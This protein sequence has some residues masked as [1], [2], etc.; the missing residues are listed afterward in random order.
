M[1]EEQTT[2]ADVPKRSRRGWLWWVG[3]AIAALAIYNLSV[4]VPASSD[5][6]EDGRAS[7][8]SMVVYRTW[9][10]HPTDITVDLRDVSTA[11][12]IDLFRG[13][14]LA[15]E[16]L[17]DREFGQVTLARGGKPVF[18]MSG[19]D[20]AAYGRYGTSLAAVQ[21]LPEQM[22]LPSGEQAFGE[23]TGGWLGVMG[24]QLEDV[25]VMAEEWASGQ[26]SSYRS[27]Y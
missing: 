1:T 24:R 26:T 2:R 8:Y 27:T 22:H 23:W 4:T 5:L 3:G 11:A 25:N 10:V 18:V 16:G 6:S 12:R 15:A 21:S 20:F 9:L 7:G 19:D 17:G 14:R 13:L